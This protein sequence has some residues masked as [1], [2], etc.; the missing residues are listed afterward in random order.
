MMKKK[1]FLKSFWII[2]LFSLLPWGTS[3]AGNDR[4]AT[5]SIQQPQ[6]GTKKITGTVSDENDV[7]IGV[8]IA[9]RGTTLGVITDYEGKFSLSV[10]ENATL[11]VSYVG[12][13]TKEFKVGKDAVYN[14]RM[15]ED[16]QGLD[17]VVVVAYGSQR[18]VS[19]I[20]AQSGIKHVEEL[21]QPVANIS[22]VLAGRIAGV[23]AV[24]RSAEPGKDNA[25]IW[26]RGIS[27][28]SNSNP[29]IIVDGVERPFGNIDPEDIESFQVL[30]DASSTAVYGVRGA[31]G[32]IMITTKQGKLG[33]PRIRMEYNRGITRLTKTPELADGVTYMQMANEA[34]MNDGGPAIFSADQIYKTYSKADPYLYPNVDWQ[35]ELFN[36]YG[37]NQKANISVNGGSEFS[38][39]YVSFGYYD[40]HGLYSTYDD[41]PQYNGRIDYTRYNF[42]T[43]LKMQ[44]TKTTE[45]AL[46]VKG[47]SSTNTAPRYSSE[48]IFKMVLKTY[49]TLYPVIYP[50]Q[51]R[52]PYLKTGGE[53]TNPRGM[54]TR[55]GYKREN[56]NQTF[57]D[58]RLKQNL[59]FWVKG[60]S[61][62]GLFSFDSWS[63]NKMERYNNEPI[64]YYATRRDINGDLVY[65]RTDV[66]L[67]GKETLDYS[68][69]N[70]ANR[71]YYLE[72][73]INY[74]GI[75]ANKHRLSGLLL[76]NQRDYENTTAGNLID[77]YPYRSLGIAGR[78][79]YSYDD[80]YLFETNFG[81]NG[82][83]NFDPNNRF[84]FFPSFGLGWAISNESW[85]EPM[86]K[87][88]QFLKFRFSWGQA[89]NSDLGGRR[90]GYLSTVESTTGFK[91]GDKRQ[92]NMGGVDI[93]YYASE[94]RW[95]NST[96]T[97]LGVDLHT[98]N[99]TLVM[100]V[101]LFTDQREAIFLDRKA[102]PDI[103]GIRNNPLGNFGI[104]D[105]KGFEVTLDWNKKLSRD[106]TVGLKGNYT[107]NE[108]EIIDDATPHPL[109]PW[110]ESRGRTRYYRTGYICDGL[111]T[112][113]EI[114][115]PSVAKPQGALAGD[116]KY[117]DL[118]VDGIIDD[119]D[120]TGIGKDPVPQIVYGFGLTA[121]YRGFNMGAFFQGVAS[122]D[123][124]INSNEFI[125]FIDGTAK[126]NLFANINDRW[127]QE[128]PRQD[129]EWPRLS[130]GKARSNYETSTFWLRNGSFLRLKTLDFGY[131]IP[132]KITKRWGVENVRAYFLG[133]NLLTFTKFDM[134]D[135]ELGSGS[136]S[137]YPNVKTYSLGL[138]LSF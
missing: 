40:E 22:T 56:V 48:D 25:D 114:D 58:L 112:Q 67:K 30:K 28:F 21:K 128:N 72:S 77:S 70:N 42:S 98:L 115:N 3:V 96:K 2:S 113:E 38:Q 102:I 33:K 82:S 138:T 75:I 50:D 135:V 122:C 68:R 51:N 53:V 62:N 111:Y 27:T 15:E 7:L 1:C 95:E 13:K 10:P 78:G 71:S 130:Y 133:Y 91:Y 126:G 106:W 47:Y 4:D 116:L 23:V 81:Y 45:L 83:E 125:P 35:D 121:S 9:V 8:T 134:W 85:W 55:Y 87:Y 90:F 86:N 64:T 66:D 101:D 88:I 63:S 24:Q 34:S 117:R 16:A 60:L 61:F 136:G 89:G 120:K 104:V 6:P 57:T 79:T 103:M 69:G 32:V 73:S 37:H 105:N 84:G 11:V 54:I 59:D 137:R 39:Y 92:N 31:N 76:Y 100:Q 44:V 132:S 17:E 14:I 118:N 99:N 19:S 26:I 18:K 94:L 123:I 107:Y 74:E 29:L 49:P 131:T 5:L 12:Y 129:A 41:E 46:G 110:M 36:N 43:N 97:N 119:Y 108:S 93:Q 127:T 65:E 20:A 124:S 109:Y 80:R 52:L